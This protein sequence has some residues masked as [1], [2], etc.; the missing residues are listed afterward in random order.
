MRADGATEERA[1]NEC[2]SDR[3][4]ERIVGEVAVSAAREHGRTFFWIWV[5]ETVGDDVRKF[6]ARDDQ[7]YRQK[8]DKPPACHWTLLCP[9]S[10]YGGRTLT[11]KE[12]MLAA[13]RPV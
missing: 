6:C 12:S 11:C 8:P 7:R 4:A 3:Q 2:G 10:E 9:G 5:D 13:A 1:N